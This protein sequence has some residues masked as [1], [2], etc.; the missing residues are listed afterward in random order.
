MKFAVIAA[1]VAAVAAKCEPA[2]YHTYI[3]N[4]K[5]CKDLNEDATKLYKDIPE[6]K[7]YLYEPGCHWLKEE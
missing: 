2:K 5:D 7:F 1:L 6:D 4:D 3:Y